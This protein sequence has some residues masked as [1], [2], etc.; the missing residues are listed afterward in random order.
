MV[1]ISAPFLLCLILGIL[2][3]LYF[4]ISFSGSDDLVAW[5]IFVRQIDDNGLAFL[6]SNEKLFNHP[7]PSAILNYLLFKLSGL[8]GV[9]FEGLFRV[10]YSL[11]DTVTALLLLRLSHSSRVAVF[12]L[13]SPLAICIGSFHGNTDA[14]Y[15]LLIAWSLVARASGKYRLF[16]FL[17]GVSASVKVITLLLLPSI[18]VYLAKERRDISSYQWLYVGLFPCIMG[19]FIYP[20]YFQNIFMY[21]PEGHFYWGVG[22]LLDL[23]AESKEVFAPLAALLLEVYAAVARLL[24]PVAVVATPV[25]FRRFRECSIVEVMTGTYLS[26]L[27]LS[28]G[29]GVQYLLLANLLLFVCSWKDGLLFGLVSIGY[30]VACYYPAVVSYFENGRIESYTP[31]KISIFLGVILF[32]YMIDIIVRFAKRKEGMQLCAACL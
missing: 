24:V 23:A 29:I 26:A 28:P 1:P 11:A 2:A 18:L 30:T 5:G 22:G 3:R 7:L 4:A 14:L 17:F 16:C 6:Y 21:V 8:L 12:W 31:S 13:L 32:A 20:G 27:C 9:G 19:I 25:L 15:V 10:F